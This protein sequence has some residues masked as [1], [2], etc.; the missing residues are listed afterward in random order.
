[1]FR[2]ND[3]FSDEGSDSSDSNSRAGSR[4]SATRSRVGVE[5]MDDPAT[6]SRVNVEAM[7]DS[8]TRSRGVNVEALEDSATRS[9]VVVE[10]SWDATRS[11][12]R[13]STATRSRVDFE[14]EDATRSP[15]YCLASLE[16]RSPAFSSLFNGV[17][18]RSPP[19]ASSATRSPSQLP[20]GRFTGET[21]PRVLSEETSSEPVTVVTTPAARPRVDSGAFLETRSWN[22][23]SDLAGTTYYREVVIREAD[24][25]RPSLLASLETKEIIAFLQSRL[26][27]FREVSSAMIWESADSELCFAD[28]VACKF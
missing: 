14:A 27:F 11:P 17:E 1:M 24:A 10:G 19:L 23:Q 25:E 20:M 3:H 13:L 16:T 15:T 21:S 18:T 6:K 2:H 26:D 4:D 7:E 28:F 9:R 22:E 5:A 8:A 12:I